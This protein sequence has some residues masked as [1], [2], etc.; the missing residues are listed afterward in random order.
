MTPEIE[1]GGGNAML[2]E[3]PTGQ[4]VIPGYNDADFSDLDRELQVSM[5]T[6]LRSMNDKYPIHI[7][8]FNRENGPVVRG[9]LAGQEFSVQRAGE[10]VSMRYIKQP[11]SRIEEVTIQY[12][13][14]GQF[15]AAQIKTSIGY[16]IEVSLHE[17]TLTM[18]NEK[19]ID[20]AREGDNSNGVAQLR[21]DT[22]YAGCTI[23]KGTFALLFVEDN[24][25]GKGSTEY[26]VKAPSQFED[27]SLDALH[28]EG[29]DWVYIP[30]WRKIGQTIS[31]SSDQIS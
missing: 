31:D 3:F 14:N 21:F 19:R 20:T 13:S 23:A 25:Q 16:N 30:E 22:C 18:R 2:L 11:T 9:K 8:R 6:S 27:S 10:S 17:G 29:T 12:G 26:A 1:F 7:H 5:T 28:S 4:S 15:Q 24:G